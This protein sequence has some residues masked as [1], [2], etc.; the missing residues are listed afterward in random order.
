MSDYIE[1]DEFKKYDTYILVL[2]IVF[3][4]YM[5]VTTLTTD[6]TSTSSISQ[7]V[8]DISV[9]GTAILLQA[10]LVYYDGKEAKSK[11][12]ALKGS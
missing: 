8:F 7:Q 3:F 10:L 12:F 5:E 2:Y 6:S 9:C 11:I 4:V 1:P